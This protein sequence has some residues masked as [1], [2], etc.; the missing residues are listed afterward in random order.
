MT[1]YHLSQSGQT[2]RAES[3]SSVSS[4]TCNSNRSDLHIGQANISISFRFI[5]TPQGMPWLSVGGI[6]P[7]NI[8]IS[9]GQI[10][11]CWCGFD[12][13]SN[14]MKCVAAFLKLKEG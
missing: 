10:F 3:I 9:S 8:K 11:G 13:W 14:G 4:N 2:R 6:D 12:Q 1:G 5:H 7:S